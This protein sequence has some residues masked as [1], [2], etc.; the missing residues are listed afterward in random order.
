MRIDTV[1]REWHEGYPK[2]KGHYLCNVD[3]EE[4]VLYHFICVMNGKHKWY[5]GKNEEIKD[6]V[7]WSHLVTN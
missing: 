4:I 3:G 7:L 2:T 6:K 5:L 1:E